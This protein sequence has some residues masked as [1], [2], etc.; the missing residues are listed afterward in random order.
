MA[1]RR[2]APGDGGRPPAGAR[3]IDRIDVAILRAL[4]HDSAGECFQTDPTQSFEEISRQVRVS[5]DTVA[6]RLSALKRSGFLRSIRL[7][8][9]PTRFGARASFVYFDAPHEADREAILAAVRELPGVPWI[10]TYWGTAAGFLVTHLH[11]RL[12]ESGLRGQVPPLRRARFLSIVPHAYYPAEGTLSEID[13]K[14]IRV[15][16]APGTWKGADIGAAVNLSARSVRH[17]LA[18]MVR[19]H[20]FFVLPDFDVGSLPGGVLATLVAFFRGEEARQSFERQLLPELADYHFLTPSVEPTYAGYFCLFPNLKRAEDLRARA[21]RFW[22][23]ESVTLRPFLALENR[24]PYLVGGPSAT[25]R[26]RE[27]A[28]GV[29]VTVIDGALATL[30]SPTRAERS[31]RAAGPPAVDRPCS[32]EETGDRRSSVPRRNAGRAH[33]SA[34]PD[35][36]TGCHPH[37]GRWICA[38]EL[39]SDS[40]REAPRWHFGA[41]SGRAQPSRDRSGV[42][43]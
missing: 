2:V 23:V 7:G 17:R 33:R 22:G 38:G 41:I 42:G 21:S 25:A 26:G 1:H 20:T 40:Y 34:K 27:P 6:R 16:D 29:G 4:L 24:L 18:R 36:V 3:A 19:S 37:R 12:E 9:N 10:V 28:E 5:A 31:S 8:L 43:T 35:L 15:L 39:V 11:P 13:W 14:I 32:G 30:E